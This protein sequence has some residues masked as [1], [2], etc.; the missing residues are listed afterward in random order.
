MEFLYTEE[1]AKE[2][3]WPCRMCEH[4]PAKKEGKNCG[5]NCGE[6]KCSNFELLKEFL[7]PS[8]NPGDK[9]STSRDCQKLRDKQK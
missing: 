7:V 5:E 9:G 6:S 2:A 3:N 1:D 4:G 8:K